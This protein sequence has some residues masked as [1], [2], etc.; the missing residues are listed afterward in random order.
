MWEKLFKNPD[1]TGKALF[2]LLCAHSSADGTFEWGFDLSQAATI[3][4]HRRIKQHPNAPGRLCTL[5]L[6]QEI[7]EVVKIWA[8]GR[9][10]PF[11]IDPDVIEYL[12]F[13]TQGHAG[14]LQ[15]VLRHLSNIADGNQ[16]LM[17]SSLVPR[18]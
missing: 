15:M 5:L 14:M 11:Q 16:V 12:E 8:A 18:S 6:P 10:H 3:P 9:V 1:H 2:V 17:T 7:G 13:E 4:L